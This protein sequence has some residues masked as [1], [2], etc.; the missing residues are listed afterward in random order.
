MVLEYGF[1]NYV[2]VRHD[3]FRCDK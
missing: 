2:R 3:S 1:G